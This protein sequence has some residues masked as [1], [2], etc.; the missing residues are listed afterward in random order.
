MINVSAHNWWASIICWMGHWWTGILP[1]TFTEVGLNL[2]STLLCWWDFLISQSVVAL[3]HCSKLKLSQDETVLDSKK[4]WE[5][6]PHAAMEMSGCRNLKA[7]WTTRKRK[8]NKPLR[9]QEIFQV[10]VISNTTK[11]NF[12]IIIFPHLKSSLFHI[13]SLWFN[14]WQFRS[15]ALIYNSVHLSSIAGL[16][17]HLQKERVNQMQ[18]ASCQKAASY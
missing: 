16:K 2:P 9:K 13:L 18:R 11:A 6:L 12:I 4:N 7:H 3:T 17:I 8:D 1:L 15:M 14:Y 10:K 5:C